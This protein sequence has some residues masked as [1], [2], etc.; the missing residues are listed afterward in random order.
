MHKGYTIFKDQ[1]IEVIRLYPNLEIK[2]DINELLYVKG[3]LDIPND[4][5]ETTGSFLIEVHHQLGFPFRFPK[6]YETGGVIPCDIDWHKYT[7]ESCCITVLPDEILECKGGITVADFIER[8]AMSYL[9]NHLYRVKEGEYLNGEYAHGAPGLTQFYEKLLLTTNKT[10]WIDYYK[11][12][13]QNKKIPCGR[14]DTCLCG[15][16]KKFKHC[17]SDVFHKL[18]L[19]GE[20]QV[21]ANFKLIT[22]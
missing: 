12:T 15:S 16:G 14:N 11:Y 7:D 8:F 22:Q 6:L 19:I 4:A 13:F 20:E 3:I 10:T 21:L 17:H 2:K 5:G 18:R 1:L 9:A